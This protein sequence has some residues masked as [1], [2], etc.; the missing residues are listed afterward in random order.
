M[1]LV[2]FCCLLCVFCSLFCTLTRIPFHCV[3]VLT[4]LNSYC[5]VAQLRW[6]KMTSGAICNGVV[7]NQVWSCQGICLLF[8]FHSWRHSNRPYGLRCVFLSYFSALIA[9]V[10]LIFFNQRSKWFFNCLLT[11][12]IC[13]RSEKHYV[14][15]KHVN[16]F[17]KLLLS[18]WFAYFII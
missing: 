9:C 12:C 2:V 10:F 18:V 7:K 16:K 11:I 14:M 15:L 3:Q 17:W 13:S 5:C 4:G 6:L 1:I 8:I